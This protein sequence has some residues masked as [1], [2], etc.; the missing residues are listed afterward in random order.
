MINRILTKNYKEIPLFIILINKDNKLEVKK[1]PCFKILNNTINIEVDKIIKYI[2]NQLK[3]EIKDD[4][5]ELNP[6]ELLTTKV[7]RFSLLI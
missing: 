4:D 7:E 2:I 3:N 6:I 5:I 1:H